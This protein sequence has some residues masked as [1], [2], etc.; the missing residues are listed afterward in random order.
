MAFD[1]RYNQC[2]YFMACYYPL[3]CKM[4]YTSFLSVIGNI[5]HLDNMNSNFHRHTYY[6]EWKCNLFPEKK[7]F[8]YSLWRLIYHFRNY[9]RGKSTRSSI[10]KHRVNAAATTFI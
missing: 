7:L 9:K 6:S 10:H 1:V 3:C 2:S 4:L 5:F 8:Q